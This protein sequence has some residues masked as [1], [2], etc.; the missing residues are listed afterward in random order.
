M[1]VGLLLVVISLSAS[2]DS[3]ES[4]NQR[5]YSGQK[6]SK[7]KIAIVTIDGVL[8]EGMVGFAIKQ[9]EQAAADEHVKAVV[10]RINSPGGSIGAS[11]DL[12]RRLCL[13]RDGNPEKKTSAK[14]IV[15]SMGSIAASGGY[16]IAVTAPTIFAERTTITGSIGVYAAFPNVKKLGD[17]YGFRMNVIKAGDV[18]D[19][20]S[21]FHD[22][23]PE[24]RQ[25]WQDSVDY[26]YSQFKKVVE[27]GRP[28]LKGKLED[29]VQEKRMKDKEGSDF[30]YV[31]RLADGGI[32][33]AEKA[34]EFGLVDQIG[35]LE[36]AISQARTKASLSSDTEAFTY[37]KPRSL[38]ESLL[39]VK[40]N[41][42]IA[43]SSDSWASGIIPR[44]WYLAPQ[45]ELSGWISAIG[46]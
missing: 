22:M 38:A 11:D 30:T 34:K 4:L 7:D 43:L 20:G 14:L 10:L 40:S 27:T 9:V 5:H 15:V 37:Q 41:Q 18:K 24:E 28:S 13:L 32:F 42:S 35:Y 33:T 21:P 1:G 36:D 12:H 31:R 3:S 26:A 8:M 17:K 6:S 16:Y 19:S 39:G 45:A 2:D 23:S 29:K 44:L 25:V 46:H